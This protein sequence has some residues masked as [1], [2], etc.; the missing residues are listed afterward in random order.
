MFLKS[1][2]GGLLYVK[3][4]TVPY[5]CVVDIWRN[6]CFH[7]YSRPSRRYVRDPE[8][9]DAADKNGN[10]QGGA[11]TTPRVTVSKTKGRWKERND[12]DVVHKIL[13][14]NG[15]MNQQRK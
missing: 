7:D 3:A 2:H 13:Y 4:S 1:A 5:G 9:R 15:Q 11:K 8:S 14:P 12:A 10:W 6:N